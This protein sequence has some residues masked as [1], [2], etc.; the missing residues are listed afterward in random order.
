[1]KKTTKYLLAVVV[2]L[3]VIGTVGAIIM[4]APIGSLAGDTAD[5]DTSTDSGTDEV[6]MDGRWAEKFVPAEVKT[7]DGDGSDVTSGTLRIFDSKPEGYENDRTVS[8]AYGSDDQVRKKTISSATTEVQLKPGTYYAVVESSGKYNGYVEFTVTDGS[9]VPVSTTLKDF[10]PDTHELTLVDAYSLSSP[11]YDLGVS[12]NHSSTYEEYQARNTYYPSDGSEYRLWKAVIQTGDVDPTTDS[13]SDGTMDE[14]IKKAWIEIK[15][16]G[17]TSDTF[18]NPNNGID[19]LG[20]NNKVNVIADD[21]TFDNDNP[22]TVVFHA[23]LLGED[24]SSA[25]DGDELT[26]DGEN[27]FDINFFD[28]RGTGN[29]V[30]NIQG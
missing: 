7:V 12:S 27:V 19:K 18:F 14:G 23:Q 3:A 10:S 16:D 13:D 22:M 25:S 9:D 5:T 8:N 17:T 2:L 20:A 4:Y 6:Q 24:G 1:M 28:D 21:M 29:S 30:A 26:S 11:S 15:G